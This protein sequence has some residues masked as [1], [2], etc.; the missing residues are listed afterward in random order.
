MRYR[1]I[2]A[3][4]QRERDVVVV[5]VTAGAWVQRNERDRSNVAGLHSCILSWMVGRVVGNREGIG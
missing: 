2:V 5:A 4:Y 1:M 3:R